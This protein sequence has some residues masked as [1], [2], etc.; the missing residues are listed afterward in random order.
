ME[1][2]ELKKFANEL[3]D[4][5]KEYNLYL[6][7]SEPLLIFSNKDGFIAAMEDLR[8]NIGLLSDEYQTVHFYQTKED[9]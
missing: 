5:L 4:L 1:T 9:R 3:H 6:D 2:E 7:T 8:L